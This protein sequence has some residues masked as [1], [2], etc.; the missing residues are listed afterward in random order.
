[1]TVLSD[2]SMIS[3]NVLI[4]KISRYITVLSTFY[5]ISPYISSNIFSY[6]FRFTMFMG[7]ESSNFFDHRRSM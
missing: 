6:Q 5:L 1:M 3:F 2:T 4:F 7:R